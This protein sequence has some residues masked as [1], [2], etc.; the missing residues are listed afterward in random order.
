MPAQASDTAPVPGK[1]SIDALD[2]GAL[3]QVKAL[4][5]QVQQADHGNL[6]RLED[7]QERPIA[8]GDYTAEPEELLTSCYR[9]YAA[10]I[11]SRSDMPRSSTHALQGSFLRL[12]H[13]V[14]FVFVFVF[15]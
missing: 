1:S 9:S 10:N 6:H 8:Q 5:A 12:N 11:L 2:E 15:S 14:F 3:S 7:L 4:A 13:F